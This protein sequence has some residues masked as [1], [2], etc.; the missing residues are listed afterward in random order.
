MYNF[1]QMDYLVTSD[2]NLPLPVLATD[3]VFLHW[4]TQISLDSARD[5]CNENLI[6]LVH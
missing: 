5:T 3:F 2:I 1:Q 6:I 4:H